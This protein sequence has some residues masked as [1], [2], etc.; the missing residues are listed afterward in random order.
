MVS[1]PCGYGEDASTRDRAAHESYV[2]DLIRE[3][4]ALIE[5]NQ[6]RQ[7]IQFKGFYAAQPLVVHNER[8]KFI[9]EASASA[10]RGDNDIKDEGFE[11][12]VSEHATESDELARG[13]YETQADLGAI[14][15]PAGLIQRAPFGPPFILVEGVQF[16]ELGLREAVHNVKQRAGVF[17][18]H[19][20]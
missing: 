1:G 14:H 12:E 20:V 6:L 7:A 11:C 9:A 15:A 2:S 4:V 13:V 19:S 17:R 16:L 5:W 8:Y 10:V 3:G 18:S